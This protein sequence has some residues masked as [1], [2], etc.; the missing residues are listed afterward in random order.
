M[1]IRCTNCSCVLCSE[2]WWKISKTTDAASG[3]P[4]NITSAGLEGQNGFALSHLVR[5]LLRQ[6]CWPIG[7]WNALLHT[8]SVPINVRSETLYL[9]NSSSSAHT[10]ILW[11][12]RIQWKYLPIL[13]K[14]LNNK[15]KKDVIK[16][17]L[18]DYTIRQRKDAVVLAFCNNL[19]STSRPTWDRF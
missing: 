14:T 11:T 2:S 4:H 10:W 5:Q 7:A 17:L 8:I 18:E 16:R 12:T 13:D 3:T 19:R 6:R 15:K 9:N 1:S